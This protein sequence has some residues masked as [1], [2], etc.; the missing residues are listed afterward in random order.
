MN[1]LEV[2]INALAERVQKVQKKARNGAIATGVIYVVL[3]LFVLAYTTV[4]MAQLR[5]TLT[6]ENV[7]AQVQNMVRDRLP[8]L[9]RTAVDYAKGQVPLLT[10]AVVGQAYTVLPIAE[11]Q[12]KRIIDN[13]IDYLL[14]LFHRDLMP[15]LK[16]VVDEHADAISLTA[17]TLKDDASRRELASLLMSE[18]EGQFDAVLGRNLK[19]ELNHFRRQLEEL[20]AKPVGDL[21]QAEAVK[22]KLIVNWLFMLDQEGS[23]QGVLV[24]LFNSI[25]NSCANMTRGIRLP[26]LR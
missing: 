4:I 1:D 18:V 17:E 9:R 16:A 7:S 23:V 22:R 15:R 14:G 8:D 25:G 3:V 21:T 12:V 2:K 13:R 10:G 6:A 20:A 5:S 24:D 26:R 19:V 11:S